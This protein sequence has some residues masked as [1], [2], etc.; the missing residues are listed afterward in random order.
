MENEN[1]T[2]PLLEDVW[3]KN[4]YHGRFETLANF[5]NTNAFNCGLR[6]YQVYISNSGLTCGIQIYALDRSGIHGRD[7]DM[8]WHTHTCSVN[9]TELGF[10]ERY[11]FL[12][13]ENI[14]KYKSLLKLKEVKAEEFEN[15][16][17]NT[18]RNNRKNVLGLSNMIGF[19]PFDCSKR[20]TQRLRG[21][22]IKVN[23][24]KRKQK[25]YK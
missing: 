15:D 12:A 7:N 9:I 19:Y 6:N 18:R 4:E 3:S 22:G 25:Q 20:N 16:L 10:I 1:K 2:I 11:V 13:S 21:V 24:D 17:I 23:R 5:L 14:D 8:I